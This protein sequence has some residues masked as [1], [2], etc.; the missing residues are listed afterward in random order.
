MTK[1]KIKNCPECGSLD[2][3]LFNHRTYQCE[4]CWVVFD[5]ESNIILR[6]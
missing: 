1:N 5:K 4:D 2:I 3:G 6:K